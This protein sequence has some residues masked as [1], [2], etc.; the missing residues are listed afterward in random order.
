MK[1]RRRYGRAKGAETGWVSGRPS[2]AAIWANGKPITVSKSGRKWVVHVMG[3]PVARS[4]AG[5]GVFPGRVGY[6]E[7]LAP[8]LFDTKD[9]AKGAAFQI[10]R[11][12]LNLGDFAHAYVGGW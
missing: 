5:A 11:Y 9:A 3:G 6:V 12:M 8:V 4:A 2:H 7:G 10:G 1:L